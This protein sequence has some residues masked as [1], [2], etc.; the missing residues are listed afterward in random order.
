M[1][2]RI[3][4]LLAAAVNLGRLH[5]LLKLPFH[6]V[7]ESNAAWEGIQPRACPVMTT[8][9]METEEMRKSD[10]RA[11]HLSQFLP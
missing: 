11:E 8:T 5:L 6:P 10:T 4:P 1:G 7:E 9:G 2:F 3:L